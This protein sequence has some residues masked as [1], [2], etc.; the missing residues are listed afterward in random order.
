[1]DLKKKLYLLRNVKGLAWRSDIRIQ[2][3]NN[4]GCINTFYFQLA[5]YGIQDKSGAGEAFLG[6]E[7]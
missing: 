3:P 5:L 4:I 6:N 7:K 2:L 1:L